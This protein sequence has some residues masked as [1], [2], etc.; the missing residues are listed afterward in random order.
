MDNEFEKDQNNDNDINEN[1]SSNENNKKSKIFISGDF[2]SKP[3]KI[4]NKLY[5]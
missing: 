1:D 4:F 3:L 5:S 2:I